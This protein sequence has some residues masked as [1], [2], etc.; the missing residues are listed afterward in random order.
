M[1]EQVPFVIGRSSRADLTLDDERVSRFHAE[2]VMGEHGLR[3]R[4]LNSVNGSF[5]AGERISD[6]RLRHGDQLRI[7]PFSLGVCLQ[8]EQLDTQ[9]ISPSQLSVHASRG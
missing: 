3:F 2:I 5:V 7:G 1:I 6:A 8:E 9:V 4:D